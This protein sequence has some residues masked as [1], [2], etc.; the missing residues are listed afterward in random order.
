MCIGP[1]LL[2]TWTSLTPSPG[3]SSQLGR[4][5]G[6][7]QTL[8]QGDTGPIETPEYTPKAWSILVREQAETLQ[9]PTHHTHSHQV[10]DADVSRADPAINQKMIHRDHVGYRPRT[11]N[12]FNIS[13]PYWIKITT[14][15]Y[16][17]IAEK[18]LTKSDTHL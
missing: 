8:R 14:E 16:A 4:L 18:H 6:C 7:C 5:W 12:W 13:K 15:S 17:H 1:C 9:E 3:G 2:H 11:L 10:P